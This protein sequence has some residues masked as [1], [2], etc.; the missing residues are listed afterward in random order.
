MGWAE[1]K[2]RVQEL[3]FG[4]VA[5]CAILVVLAFL[6]VVSVYFVWQAG[7][8][9]QAVHGHLF[10]SHVQYNLLTTAI[11]SLIYLA[12]A[13][14]LFF[15]NSKFAVLAVLAT[16]MYGAWQAITPLISDP[17]DR[18]FNIWVFID[19]AILLGS[20]GY[21]LLSKKIERIY[22]FGSRQFFTTGIRDIWLR[23][24]GRPSV[25]QREAAGLDETF[26]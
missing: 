18:L 6:S 13:F 20:I 21:L 15:S 5:L 22:H 8:E 16:L 7:Q 26:R 3:G 23:G 17:M 25:E 11:R 12:G 2:L 9:L 4:P 24:R 1:D 10:D 19:L 14:A